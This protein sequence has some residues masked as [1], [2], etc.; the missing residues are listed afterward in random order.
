MAGSHPDISRRGF[1]KLAAGAGHCGSL[2][3]DPCRHGWA[4]SPPLIVGADAELHL[5]RRISFGPTAI[6]LARVREMG[7]GGAIP[8]PAPRPHTQ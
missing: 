6:E 5:L 2:A 4:L 7:Q 8:A 3:A 1:F